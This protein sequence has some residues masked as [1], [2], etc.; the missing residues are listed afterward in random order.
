VKLLGHEGHASSQEAQQGT[1]FPLDFV[2]LSEAEFEPVGPH[3]RESHCAASS[4]PFSSSVR[5]RERVAEWE[6]PW[7][8][9]QRS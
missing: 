6:L 3:L 1:Y 7:P 8:I 5:R 4:S 9:P 2:Q